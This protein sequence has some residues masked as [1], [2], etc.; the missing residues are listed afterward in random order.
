VSIGLQAV[1]IVKGRRVTV[2]WYQGVIELPKLSERA[3][4][5]ILNKEAKKTANPK[6]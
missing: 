3:W 6:P 4:N 5:A 1:E 2:M